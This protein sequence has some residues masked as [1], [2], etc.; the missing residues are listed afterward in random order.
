MCISSILRGILIWLY[1]I[2]IIKL[3]QSIRLIMEKQKNE[4]DLI[5]VKYYARK[6]EKHNFSSVKYLEIFTTGT[7][8][9]LSG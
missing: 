9:W 2:H 3:V 1:L 6:T 4:F 7:P 8:G 5:Y